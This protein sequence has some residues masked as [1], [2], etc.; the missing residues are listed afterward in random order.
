MALR[1]GRRIV[2]MEPL[3]LRW[4]R[5]YVREGGERKGL[6]TPRSN[7]RKRLR[8]IRAA[9]GFERWPQDAPRRTYASCW[10]AIHADVDRLNRLMGHTSPEMLSKHYEKAVTQKQARA[11]WKIEPPPIRSKSKIIALAAA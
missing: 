11:F 6:V 1:A 8:A 7:L 2:K 10:L 9:A 3:L 5:Y 4:L